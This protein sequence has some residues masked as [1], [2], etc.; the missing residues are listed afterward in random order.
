MRIMT[1]LMLMSVATSWLLVGCGLRSASHSVAPAS[2]ATATIAPD[3]IEDASANFG[4]L[5]AQMPSLERANL[6]RHLKTVAYKTPWAVRDAFAADDGTLYV[7]VSPIASVLSR[8]YFGTL[9]EGKFHFFRLPSISSEP[10]PQPTI[11]ISGGY[12]SMAFNSSPGASTAVVGAVIAGGKSYI[13]TARGGLL[14]AVRTAGSTANFVGHE[15]DFSLS[16]GEECTQPEDRSSV[17]AV[18]AKSKSGRMRPLIRLGE[19]KAATDGILTNMNFVSVVC[20]HFA[21]QDFVEL[22]AG[23][24]VIFRLAGKQLIPIS[25]GFIYETGR[26]RMLIQQSSDESPPT[27]VI[28]LEA[29]APSVRHI[30][31][32]I[33][34][35]VQI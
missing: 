24:P 1:G 7:I 34:D 27:Y 6:G 22:S 16:T 17:I 18:F 28:L 5:Y 23:E 31:A 26:T 32:R 15:P 14:R 4:R 35:K 29:F 2:R 20:H 11:P 3:A 10:N 8:Y 33:H 13:F 9:R 30:N 25:R 12:Q 19:I 21:G